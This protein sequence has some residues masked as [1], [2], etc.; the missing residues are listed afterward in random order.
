[1]PGL[2]LHNTDAANRTIR[3]PRR[4]SPMDNEM[5][6]DLQPDGRDVYI[7]RLPVV[8]ESASR[9]KME[10]R[11]DGRT[12]WRSSQQWHSSV[13]SQLGNLTSGT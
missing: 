11:D 7:V 10:G 12:G 13:T 6:R 2:A 8:C 1:M 9:H 3:P 5:G 4:W